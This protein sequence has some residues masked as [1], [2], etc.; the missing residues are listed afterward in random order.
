MKHENY[1]ALCGQRP[2]RLLSQAYGN[3]RSLV[4]RRT[5]QGTDLAPA[6]NNVA[7]NDA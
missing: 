5:D 7:P 2:Q 3:S 6:P 1:H 4:R